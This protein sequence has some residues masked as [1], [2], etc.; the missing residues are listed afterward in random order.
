MVDS[1]EASPDDIEYLFVS[2]YIRARESFI[3]NEDRLHARERK[4]LTRTTVHLNR[5]F[6]VPR[7]LNPIWAD[8]WTH[9]S[10]RA[11]DSD[12]ATREGRE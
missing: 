8:D 4:D 2:R 7:I 3:S 11:I 6:L 5:E 12:V 10:I 1:T 9:G